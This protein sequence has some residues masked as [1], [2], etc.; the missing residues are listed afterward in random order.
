MGPD[1]TIMKNG[2]SIVHSQLC[3]SGRGSHC[4]NR[5][6]NLEEGCCIKISCDEERIASFAGHLTFVQLSDR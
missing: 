6:L 1:V 4:L 2:K 5:V 3:S